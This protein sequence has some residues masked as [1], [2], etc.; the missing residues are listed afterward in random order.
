MIVVIAAVAA[1]SLVPANTDMQGEAP[2]EAGAALKLFKER[3][4]DEQ[5]P[6]QEIVVFSSPQYKVTD[7]IYKDTVQA[8]MA[9]LTDL[10]ETETTVR[11]R[12][13]GRLQHAGGLRH[14]HSL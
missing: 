10:R 13:D 14:A 9:Q 11:G 1:S 3:F 6:T 5:V 7:P 12:N 8:L 2:G 4:G